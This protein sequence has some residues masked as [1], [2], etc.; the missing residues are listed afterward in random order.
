MGRPEDSY[1]MTIDKRTGA[2]SPHVV[3]VEVGQRV[4]KRRK[5]LSMTQEQL[6]AGLGLTFQQ[7]QKYERGINRI[8]ASKLYDI[9]NALKVSIDYFFEDVGEAAQT[10]DLRE[11]TSER[12]AHAFLLTAEGLEL[13]Q[14][15]PQIKSAKQRRK[16]AELVHAMAGDAEPMKKS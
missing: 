14:T 5:F 10:S 8:S 4:R 15:Y 6:A 16:I 1:E 13:A 7:V 2:Q 11:I 3:D 12:R 9:S